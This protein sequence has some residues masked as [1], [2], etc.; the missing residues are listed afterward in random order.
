MKQKALEG[1]TA[2]AKVA[3]AEQTKIGD[4]G[5]MQHRAE[6]RQRIATYEKEAKVAENERAREIALSL[7]ELEIAKADFMKRQQIAKAEADA[8]AQ[9][10]TFE[11]QTSVEMSKNKQEVERLRAVEFSKANIQA[12]ISIKV[13]EG[14]AESLR[15]EAEGQAQAMKIEAE[16]FATATKLKAEA[17]A[18]AMKLKAEAMFIEKENE[19]KGILKLREAEAEGLQRLIEASGN[20]DLLNT[21][22]MVRDRQLLE[23]AEQQAKAVKDMKP[24][25]TIVQSNGSNSSSSGSSVG[26]VDTMNQFMR[27]AVP[28]VNDLKS[29]TGIDLLKRFR[30]ENK[31]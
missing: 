10:R 6:T 5:E 16:A 9:Q 13:A 7:A 30:D 25:I 20:V 29:S 19:A 23:I 1:A 12:E 27:S 28:L 8:S 3:V 15:R 17:D 26:L 31:A 11:L 21:Y 2:T 22:L 24:Q 14:K 4:I 18:I